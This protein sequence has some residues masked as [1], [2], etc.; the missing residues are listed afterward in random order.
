MHIN[1]CYTSII[2]VAI[3]HKQIKMAVDNTISTALISHP[4]E[5]FVPVKHQ[6]A[7]LLL[8]Q[9]HFEKQSKRRK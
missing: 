3:G 8:C 2:L 6:I 4:L 5:T 9:G 1:A 7:L